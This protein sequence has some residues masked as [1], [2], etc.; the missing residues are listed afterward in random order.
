V[1]EDSLRDLVALLAIEKKQELKQHCR[2]VTIMQRDFADLI[3]T[4]KTGQ[5][6]WMH[7][8]HHRNYT[9]EH[10]TLT[11]KDLSALAANGVGRFKPAAQKPANKVF[12]MFDDRRLLS[13][14]M[15]FNDDLS[16]W[17]FFYFDQR[18]FDR[19]KNHWHGG[20]HI[21]CINKLWPNRTAQ[22]VWTEF[23]SSASPQMRNALHIRYQRQPSTRPRGALGGS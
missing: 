1:T 23:C 4:A 20:P 9:P 2:S 5:L 17:H 14:H 16:D 7:R 10:L 12:A 15:F 8:A 18:D 22:S 6:P 13:G 3:L 11:E 19:H 21:H